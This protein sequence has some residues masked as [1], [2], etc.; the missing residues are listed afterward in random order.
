MHLQVQPGKPY[1]NYIYSAPALAVGHAM[2]ARVRAA[3]AQ[4][5]R[6]VHLI[7][8]VVYW[9]AGNGP[10]YAMQVAFAVNMT[11]V[12]YAIGGATSG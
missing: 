6:T 12:N 4:P 9:P 2:L 8:G 3:S 10:N 11:L 5:F 7:K 1:F